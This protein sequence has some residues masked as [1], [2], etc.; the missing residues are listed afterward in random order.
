MLYVYACC[1]SVFTE[2]YL[3]KEY[4]IYPEFNY[5]AILLSVPSK[6]EKV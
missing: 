6:N 5:I 1:M 4:L 2:I 3:D